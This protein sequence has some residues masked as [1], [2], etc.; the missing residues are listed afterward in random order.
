MKWTLLAA[1]VAASGPVLAGT[2]TVPPPGGVVIDVVTANGSSCRPGTVAVALSP[3]REA[4]TVTYSEY[5]AAAGAGAKTGDATRKCKLTVQLQVPDGVAYAVT[6]ADYRGFASLASGANAV[7]R[8]S[9]RFQG[10]PQPTPVEHPFPGPWAD[11]WQV[12]DRTEPVVF[13]PCGKARKFTIDTELTVD[14][15]TATAQSNFIVMDSTD[16]S[17][18]TT[19]R[20]AWRSC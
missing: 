12:T 2:A 13:G 20:I 19:Y 15:G 14:A 11:D 8:A 17:F 3:D 7:L 6:Q 5:L 4:F 16:G 1:V 18:G 10:D 9:Y